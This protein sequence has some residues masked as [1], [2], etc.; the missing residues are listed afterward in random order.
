MLCLQHPT[1]SPPSQLATTNSENEIQIDGVVLT[2][3]SRMKFIHL[4]ST[5]SRSSNRH[6]RGAHPQGSLCRRWSA[7]TPRPNSRSNSKSRFTTSFLGGKVP[8][9][10]TRLGVWLK[11]CRAVVLS[12]FL[13]SMLVNLGVWLKVCRAVLYCLLQSVLVNRGVWLKVCVQ[14]SCPVFLLHSVFVSL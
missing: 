2:A 1:S 5:L 3:W 10:Q 9:S 14:L 8:E 12:C 4:G 7:E 13:Q 11:L 6:G